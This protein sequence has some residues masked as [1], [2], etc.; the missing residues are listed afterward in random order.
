ML[1]I[2]VSTVSVIFVLGC[3]SSQAPDKVADK[4]AESENQGEGCQ[5][6]LGFIQEGHSTTGYL[7][8]IE[9]GGSPCQQGE[10]FC[11]N[12]QWS[13]TYIYPTCTKL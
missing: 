2:L 9:Q 13:G 6:P 1:R 5:S 10:L 8:P 4:A 3:A 7:H 11:K 12:G